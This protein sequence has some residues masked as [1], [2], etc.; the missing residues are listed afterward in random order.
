MEFFTQNGEMTIPA[1]SPLVAENIF[2]TKTPDTDP[3]PVFEEIKDR[4][5]HPVWAGHDDHIRCYWRAWELAFKNLQQPVP[6]TGFVSNFIDTAF[7][8]CLF[9][10]DSVFILMFGKYADRIFKFQKTLD[11]M[12]SHQ[13]RDGFICRE[14]EENTGREHFSRHDP[15]ATGPEVMP[16]CEWEYYL[17]FGDAERLAQVFPPLMAYHRW[18]AEHHTWPDG[19]YFSSGWG[20]GMDNTPRQEAEYHFAFSHGH[21]IWVDACMQELLSC[22]VLIEMAKILHRD[23]FIEELTRERDNLYR[24]INEKLWNEETH[25]YYDLWKN[26][27]HNMVRHVGAFWALISGCAPK[28]RAE[29]MIAYLSDEGEFKA[30][31]RVPTLAKSHPDYASNGRYWCGGIWSPT[32]YMVLKGLDRYDYFDLSH[33]IGKEHLD[34]VVDV[35]RRTNTLY[36]NYSPE[37]IFEGRPDKGY[38]AKADFVGWTGLVPI[39]VLFEYVFGIKPN[40]ETNTLTWHIS[41]LEEHGIEKY[42]FGTEGELTLMC[43]ARNTPDEMPGITVKSNIPL[44]LNIIWGEGENKH[45]H[46]IQVLPG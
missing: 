38:P 3:L 6:G 22:N 25:F 12:Y 9:M 27:K 16:W 23:E 42:P 14:I 26:G 1:I 31:H 20:C 32:N 43:K 34:A 13:H 15:S 39:S 29:K 30:P 5:P 46:V 35:F 44:T 21:M 4:L 18:M 10:W 28:D 7:N 24:V 8:R 40:A 17:N 19:T 37:L 11:N 33:E 36:E 45:S 41:L 2:F